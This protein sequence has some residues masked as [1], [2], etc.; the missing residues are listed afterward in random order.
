MWDDGM[1]VSI[2]YVYR[3]STGQSPCSSVIT[4]EQGVLVKHSICRH[5]DRYEEVWVGIQMDHLDVLQ[6]QVP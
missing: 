6:R 3:Y 5:I 1:S 2:Q 4:P